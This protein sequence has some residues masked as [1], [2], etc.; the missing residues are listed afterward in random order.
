MSR[1]SEVGSVSHFQVKIN[2]RWK[3]LSLN[4]KFQNIAEE[5]GYLLKGEK[6]LGKSYYWTKITFSE[7]IQE[8]SDTRNQR[9]N[10]WKTVLVKASES[11]KN[12]VKESNRIFLLKKQVSEG[13][14]K[15]C[16]KLFQKNHP[17]WRAQAYLAAIENV[18]ILLMFLF[19]F[20]DSYKWH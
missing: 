3:S 16:W 5:C 17:L 4:S 18:L 1:L 13:G 9:R 14:V 15:S 10:R 20:S 6:K 12:L 8:S 19:I 7:Q 11:N 2:K